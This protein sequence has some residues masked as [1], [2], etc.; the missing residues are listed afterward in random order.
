MHTH[1]KFPSIVSI[2]VLTKLVKYKE[3]SSLSLSPQCIYYIN[4]FCIYHLDSINC[5]VQFSDAVLLFTDLVPYSPPHIHSH[6]NTFSSGSHRHVILLDSLEIQLSFHFQPSIQPEQQ[7][8]VDNRKKV[9]N[10]QWSIFYISLFSA[11]KKK[12]Y[13]YIGKLLFFK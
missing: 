7:L 6:P 8:D 10:E 1:R 2:Y 9:S 12:F 13:F 5:L 4:V 11:V 3:L